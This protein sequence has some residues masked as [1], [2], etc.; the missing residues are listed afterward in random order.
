M[1]MDVAVLAD[2]DHSNLNLLKWARNTMSPLAK[3][4][5]VVTE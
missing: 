5:D 4:V 3:L 1:T 2:L